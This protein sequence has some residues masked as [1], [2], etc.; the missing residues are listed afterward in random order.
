VAENTVKQVKIRVE[1]L[2]LNYGAVKALDNVSLDILDNEILAITGPR[3]AGKTSLLD[4]ISGFTRP[5]SGQ[6]YLD[7][8]KITAI[9]PD[10]AAH[11][12]I[13]RTFQNTELLTGLSTLENLMSARHMMMTKNFL[14]GAFYFGPAVNE[15]T[16]QRRTVEDI[17]NFLGLEPVRMEIVGNLPPALQKRVEFGR[18]LALEPEVLLLDEPFTVD[19]PAENKAVAG[20]M[21]DIFKGEGDAYPRTKVLRDGIK[22]IVLT[23]EK[24]EITAGIAGRVVTMKSG[25]AG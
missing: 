18:A 17:I 15:E 16:D 4:C 3:G 24:P 14:T 13:A 6:I 25:K 2:S 5:Q 8:S 12:G 7:D 11:L 20:F 22:C 10:R 1:N 9:R 21:R 23:A 19:N